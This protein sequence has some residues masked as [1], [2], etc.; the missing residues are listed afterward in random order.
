[1]AGLF[2]IFGVRSGRLRSRT[3][4]DDVRRLH[5]DVQRISQDFHAVLSSDAAT[6]IF[7]IFGNYSR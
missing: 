3:P 5:R 6:C 2:D 7:A 4:E 1:M